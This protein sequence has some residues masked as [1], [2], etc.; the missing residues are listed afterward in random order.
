[1]RGGIL[2]EPASGILSASTED[3]ERRSDRYF[4]STC[5]IQRSVG[6]APSPSS[7]FLLLVAFRN[8]SRVAPWIVDEC[9]KKKRKKKDEENL[10]I[11]RL[12]AVVTKRQLRALCTKSS[13]PKTLGS[14][15]GYSEAAR[16]CF[17]FFPF[18]FFFLLLRHTP[19]RSS[20]TLS[21]YIRHQDVIMSILLWEGWRG[22]RVK[23]RSDLSL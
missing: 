2:C 18:S 20:G 12:P 17:F 7:F 8:P 23:G 5:P 22:T 1:M 14:P 4:R 10:C 6:P 11:E 13:I 3:Y 19:L 21:Y 15:F 16:Q 9:K